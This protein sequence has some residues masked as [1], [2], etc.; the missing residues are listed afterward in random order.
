MV[1]RRTYLAHV[2]FLC[3][4]GL[5]SC[6]LWS[7]LQAV[8]KK[9]PG[10]KER[11]RYESLL[12]IN[13]FTNKKKR[14]DELQYLGALLVRDACRRILEVFDVTQDKSLLSTIGRAVN[15]KMRPFEIVMVGT[16]KE[17]G[18]SVSAAYDWA[19]GSA[20]K[21]MWSGENFQGKVLRDNG[22]IASYLSGKDETGQPRRLTLQKIKEFLNYELEILN[23]RYQPIVKAI[24]VGLKKQTILPDDITKLK[25]LYK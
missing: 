6:F 16:P 7:D 1:A 18:H 8:I 3:A 21:L 12:S 4:L 19:S 15:E 14:F 2:A 23:Q 20:D 17:I 5:A 25:D 24:T 9:S 13:I 11:E 10:S 22:F